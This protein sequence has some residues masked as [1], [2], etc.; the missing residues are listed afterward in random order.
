MELSNEE[1]LVTKDGYDKLEKEYAY[2]KGPRRTE[3]AKKLEV[4]REYG[5]LSEN[6]E[7]DDAKN[8]QAQLE[9]RIVELENILKMA[10][11]VKETSNTNK[12]G[13]GSTVKLYD[14]EFDEEI[15]YTLVGATEVDIKN[16]KI[17]TASPVG[18]ALEGHKKGDE[19]E[20][21]VGGDIVKYKILDIIK[22]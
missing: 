7:Y 22:K 10:K 21:S 16:G 6:A 14:F 13:I 4:A 15:V 18:K 8:E 20:V 11:I 12:V 3:V 5:D 19:F 2:L 1:I 9:A 17:S